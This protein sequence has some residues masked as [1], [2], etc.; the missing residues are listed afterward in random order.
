MGKPFV[1]PP[2]PKTRNYSRG[3]PWQTDVSN[4]KRYTLIGHI[5]R[6]Q[7][8]AIIN[9]MTAREMIG[10]KPSFALP[11]NV[12]STFLLILQNARIH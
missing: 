8:L 4:P 2:C 7:T 12:T 5:R 9:H 6:S 3:Q 1:V 11:K 10:V